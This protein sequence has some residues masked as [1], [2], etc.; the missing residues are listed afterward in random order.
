MA[1]LTN[2]KIKD[3]YDGL[4]KTQDST[5]GIPASGKVLIE[6]G[7]GND[8]ALSLG[9]AN[10]GIS[11]TG[12]ITG[13]LTGNVTG[14]VTGNLSGNISTSTSVTGSL[15]VS[16]DATISGDLKVQN[17]NPATKAIINNTEGY[18]TKL[19]F[20]QNG[21]GQWSLGQI[22]PVEN[23]G[24]FSISQS[25]T[26][27]TNEFVKIT[28]SSGV[29]AKFGGS[30]SANEL[31]DYEEGTYN[32]TFLLDTSAGPTFDATNWVSGGGTTF[33]NSSKY[34][35]VG[36]QVTIYFDL[37]Y[38]GKPT[39]MTD[40]PLYLTNL[41]FSIATKGVGT[42]LWDQIETLSSSERPTL[43]GGA[44]LLVMTTAQSENAL[45]FYNQASRG[46]YGWVISTFSATDFPTLEAGELVNKRFLGTLTYYTNQ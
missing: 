20:Q 24:R 37:L 18:S 42:F 4:L 1:T 14:N 44:G 13:D 12:A 7:L 32:L 25:G 31:D 43:Y 19:E 8:S 23:D 17:N 15:S 27:G 40:A 10:N 6:D 26:L 33:T 30:A 36:R 5:Q 28:S 41:P 38:K 11:V 34:I 16:S 46:D 21:T 39:A 2:T 9:R 29:K 45:A 3:T 35:K 22:S